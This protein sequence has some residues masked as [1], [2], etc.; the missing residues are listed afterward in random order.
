MITTAK[1]L[2]ID[3]LSRTEQLALVQEIWNLIAAEPGTL[4]SDAERSELERRAAEDDASPDAVIPWE[5]AKA[6]TLAKLK[7]P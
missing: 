5:S 4:L 2:G 7:K 1:S 3:Q 6:D